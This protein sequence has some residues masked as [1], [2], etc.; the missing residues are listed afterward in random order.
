ML[1]E[2]NE[3][4]HRLKE[5]LAL[6]S[7]LEEKQGKLW[8]QLSLEEKILEEVRITLNKEHRDVEKLE[9]LSFSNLI[10]T[11]MNNK[12]EKLEKEQHEYL[13]AKIK[14]DQQNSKV[15]LIKESIFSVQDRLKNLKECEKE[16]KDLIEKKLKIVKF[17]GD[18]SISIKLADLEE[19]LDKDLK[20]YKEIEEA[21]TIGKTLVEAIE[22]AVDSLE[23]AKILG[24]WDITG[25]GFFTSMAKLDKIDEAEAY[26]INISNLIQRFNK[27]L[28]DVNISSLS[29]SSADVAFEVLFDNIFTDLSVQ[30]QINDSLSNITYLSEKIN[31]I[32]YNLEHEKESLSSSIA[33]KRKEY[34]EFIENL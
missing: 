4:I 15:E 16:H 34:E 9:K 26:F 13:M 18:S 27:E 6:K 7:V 21:E 10:A 3:R 2:I 1:N 32:M 33:T 25:G 17:S 8:K 28:G 11:V 5:D 24:V 19:G 31:E 30:S 20:V 29:F 14:Y 23:S 22:A 12:Y